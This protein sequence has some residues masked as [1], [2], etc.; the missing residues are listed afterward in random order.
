MPSLSTRESRL[1]VVVL[2]TG[3]NLTPEIQPYLCRDGHVS[4]AGPDLVDRVGHGTVVAE[5]IAAQVDPALV[6]LTIV[7]WYDDG[8]PYDARGIIAGYRHAR[9]I[10]ARVIN[11]SAG[12][13]FAASAE[14]EEIKL[15][16]QAGIEFVVAAGNSSQNFDE[17]CNEYPACYGFQNFRNFVVV[18][19]LDG[20]NIAE[21][22]NYGA[23][24]HEYRE[25]SHR[26]SGMRGT[27]FA[28]PV[29]AG[30]IASRLSE[31]HRPRPY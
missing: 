28:A 7:K 25:G 31:R 18:G 6:C 22:S 24:V 23:G 19:A 10:G 1:R 9:R 20:K 29:V 13:Y 30:E 2:D 27:S 4:F 11:Y 12:G 16:L 8:P 14:Y 17:A 21:Y 5:L 15:L 26:K 3:L